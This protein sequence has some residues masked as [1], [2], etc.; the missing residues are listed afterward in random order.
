MRI[1]QEANAEFLRCAPWESFII[2]IFLSLDK[3][4]NRV[5][6]AI[7][8]IIASRTRFSFLFKT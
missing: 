8:G 1:F 3:N 4:E 6:D 5:R 2:Q 7:E